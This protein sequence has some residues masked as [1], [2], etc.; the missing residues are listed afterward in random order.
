MNWKRQLLLPGLFISLVVQSQEYL[1]DYTFFA[2]SRM[3]GNYFFSQTS[4]TG[5]SS[6]KNQDNRLLVNETIFHTP[7][8]ALQ[9]EYQNHKNGFWQATIFR[10]D[11]RGQ[12]FFRK[13]NFLSFWIYKPSATTQLKDLPAVRLMKRDSSFTNELS[14]SAMEAN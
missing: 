3:S 6:I 10:Q 12:D 14:I 13:A 1:Y 8:N 2:N 7:G 5:L 9:L 4:A 11:L